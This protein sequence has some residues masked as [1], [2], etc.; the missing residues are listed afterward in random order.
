MTELY[1][2][3]SFTFYKDLLDFYIFYWMSTKVC[4]IDIHYT[5]QI[6]VSPMIYQFD[7]KIAPACRTLYQKTINL[8]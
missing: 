4:Q 2:S 5:Y 3:K 6:V 1:A 8:S 7:S